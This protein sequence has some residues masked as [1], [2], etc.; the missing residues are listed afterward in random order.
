MRMSFFLLSL[1]RALKA[2]LLFFV[3]SNEL[4]TRAASRLLLFRF[5]RKTTSYKDKKKKKKINRK[6][7]YYT[8]I[9]N[10][11]FV[12][13]ERRGKYKKKKKKLIVANG[14]TDIGIR[15]VCPAGSGPR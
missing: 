7:L 15:R 5:I 11:S 13:E 1:L 12:L 4:K 10:I 3:P 6:S 14:F 9:R 8:R 2:A